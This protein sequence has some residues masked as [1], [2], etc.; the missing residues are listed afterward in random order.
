M[1]ER[2]EREKQTKFIYEILDAEKSEI[3]KTHQQAGWT[4]QEDYVNLVHRSSSGSI[5]PPFYGDQPPSIKAI[6]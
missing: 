3:Y 4:P 5:F 6:N 2:E 1:Y